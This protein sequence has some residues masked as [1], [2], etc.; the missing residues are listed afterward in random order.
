MFYFKFYYIVMQE[1]IGFICV[2][3][4][5]HVYVYNFP[6]LA[7]LIWDLYMQWKHFHMMLQE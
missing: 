1:L 6:W 2:C 7:V 5:I 3:M 4:H